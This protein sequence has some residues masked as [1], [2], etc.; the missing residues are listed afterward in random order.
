MLKVHSIPLSIL[1]C[2]S[3]MPSQETF[4]D[5]VQTS[6]AVM[7]IGVE[8]LK[9]RER[10]TSCVLGRKKKMGYI[11]LLEE[12]GTKCSVVLPSDFGIF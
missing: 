3:K 1:T 9:S 6:K 5:D 10:K 12:A 2:A 8:K 7:S 11:H 4:R